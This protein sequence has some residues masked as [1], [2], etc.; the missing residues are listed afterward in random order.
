[1]ACLGECVSMKEGER[2]LRGIVGTPCALH[3]DLERC[4][5]PALSRASGAEERQRS[6]LK[7]QPPSTHA[8]CLLITVGMVIRPRPGEPGDGERRFGPWRP[9]PAEYSRPR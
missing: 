4:F 3:H 8:Q 5:C 2:G 9:Q 1:M 6:Q 7:Q